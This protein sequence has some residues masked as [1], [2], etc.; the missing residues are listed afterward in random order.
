MSREDANRVELENMS[1]PQPVINR[2][3]IMAVIQLL[4]LAGVIIPADVA[5]TLAE[6]LVVIL[7]PLLTIVGGLWASRKVTP[8]DR[9][10]VPEDTFVLRYRDAA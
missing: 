6:A 3:L 7:P 4:G 10:A 2:A 1:R 5:S 8:I 9:P